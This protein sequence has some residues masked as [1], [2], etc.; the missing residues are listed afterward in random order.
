MAS[1]TRPLP[2]RTE[3]GYKSPQK[4]SLSQQLADL[5]VSGTERH[6]QRR[7]RSA[8]KLRIASS[9]RSQQARPPQLREQQTPFRNNIQESPFSGRSAGPGSS[10]PGLSSLPRRNVTVASSL[11]DGIELKWLSSINRG[12]SD[13][14]F[15]VNSEVLI[16]PNSIFTPDTRNFVGIF[17]N[18]HNGEVS[19]IYPRMRFRNF[20]ETEYSDSWQ[21]IPLEEDK[22]QPC[23]AAP[24]E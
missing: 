24:C 7:H 1:K 14:L 23:L 17:T 2:S 8:N 5:A 13:L 18:T 15:Q 3:G 10:L 19:T 21:L 12:D 20:G 9:L 22:R 16:A 11:P 6:S 4:G